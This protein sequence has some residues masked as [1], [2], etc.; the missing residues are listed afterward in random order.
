LW[1]LV[2]GFRAQWPQ[3]VPYSGRFGADPLPHL[4]LARGLRAADGAMIADRLRRFLPLTA[5]ADKVWL[6][7]YGPPPSSRPAAHIRR[8]RVEALPKSTIEGGYVAKAGRG[9]DV[10][11]LAGCMIGISQKAV[12]AC[13]ALV[14][15][16]L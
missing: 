13:E 1:W 15:N 5:S 7:A 2:A 3:L 16:V 6:V 9:G 4:T 14:E 8:G 12:H 11:D 10:A